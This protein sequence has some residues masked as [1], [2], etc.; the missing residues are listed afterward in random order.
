M[1]FEPD[2]HETQ[3]AIIRYL[4]FKPH[5]GFAELQKGNQSNERSL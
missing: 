3:L 5:A 1:S 2:V 4:L